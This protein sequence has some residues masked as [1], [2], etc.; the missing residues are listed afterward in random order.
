[1]ARCLFTDVELG[2]DTREEHTIQR[3]VGGRVKSFEVSSSAFNELCG[4]RIDP[5][6]CGAY[7]E[8]MRVLGPALPAEAR[9]GSTEFRIPN[10]PGRWRFNER[11]QMVLMDPTVIE[12]DPLSDRPL[13]AIGPDLSSLKPMIRQLGSPAVRHTEVLPPSNE[14]VF[15]E[16][17]ALHWGI[18]VAALKAALLTF[19]HL[20]RDDP[21][22]FTRRPELEPVRR[23]VREVVESDSE[24]P[25]ID[26]L[27]DISLGVQYD[28]DL[29]NLYGEI[30]RQAGLASFPFQHTLIVSG[31]PGSR[32]LDVV[33][34]AF[35]T[36]PHV[37]RVTRDWSG[38][39]F[40][41]AMTNGILV[42][43]EFSQVATLARSQLLGRPTNRRCRMR[44]TRD[45]TD[46]ERAAAGRELAEHRGQLY[47]RAVDYVERHCD[48][49][50][51][52]QLSRLARLN[53]LGD[54]RLS[55]AVFTHL[56][57]LFAGKV[58][59]PVAADEFVCRLIPMID[60]A[61][62]DTLPQGSTA[63]EA[64]QRGWA[65]W[66]SL[67]RDCLDQLRESFGM[68]GHI[69]QHAQRLV[70]NHP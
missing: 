24:N 43:T 29:L 26:L 13:S 46:A 12:R 11:G 37:F 14:V 42:D 30:K 49:S 56:A 39:G 4:E 25:G 66:L 15:E 18:E 40:T 69:Y 41:L 44:V 54:H 62:G 48:G 34:W 61:P 47:R 31:E 20:L 35:E 58:R 65:F 8:V 59:D 60:P 53:P 51:S 63:A 52:E 1:M 7:A 36:D 23:F 28:Q 19:D 5:Y 2:A 16:R 67:Y 17:A 50:V 10:H 64:P 38:A 6:L 27:A 22:R 57:T 70:V 45:L 3:S 9:S 21:E 33:F 32:A 55:S 68:P